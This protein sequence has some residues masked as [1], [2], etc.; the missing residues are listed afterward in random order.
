M[1]MDFFSR[2]EGRPQGA[3]I[4]GVLYPLS[5]RHGISV[6]IEQGPLPDGRG[7]ECVANTARRAP[8]RAATV[9]E[10]SLPIARV[11]SLRLLSLRPGHNP[12]TLVF[13]RRVSS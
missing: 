13:E 11:K 2:D 12:I 9:R 6:S 5:E 7:S 3:R 10:R 1:N 4:S 8:F